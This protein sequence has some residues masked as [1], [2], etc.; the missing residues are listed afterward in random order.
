MRPVDEPWTRL[1]T[2]WDHERICM[3]CCW[4]SFPCLARPFSWFTGQVEFAEILVYVFD[5]TWSKDVGV[6]PCASCGVGGDGR[7]YAPLQI[8]SLLPPL[9]ET[10][11]RMRGDA[12]KFQQ[13]KPWGPLDIMTAVTSLP[14]GTAAKGGQAVLMHMRMAS[15][16]A[17]LLWGPAWLFES[18]CMS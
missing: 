11:C 8:V 10:V 6:V 1:G 14:Y 5:G 4:L 18:S 15:V 2:R 17:P 16:D 9:S 12:T 13:Y 7:R 3:V